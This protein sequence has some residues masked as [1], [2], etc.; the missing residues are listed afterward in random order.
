MTISVSG[1]ISVNPIHEGTILS[2]YGGYRHSVNILM[3]NLISIYVNGDNLSV[4]TI[5]IFVFSITE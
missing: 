3:L 5:I 4:R 2:I 1:E